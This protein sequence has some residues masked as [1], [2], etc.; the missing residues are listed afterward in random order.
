MGLKSWEVAKAAAQVRQHGRLMCVLVR[1]DMVMM[2][3][4]IMKHQPGRPGIAIFFKFF[5]E[6]ATVTQH[7]D[8]E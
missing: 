5:I 8:M 1:G 2:M 6:L 3:M 4:M 7:S